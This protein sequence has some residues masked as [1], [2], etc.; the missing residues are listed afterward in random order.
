MSATEQTA[1]NG[2][3]GT[4]APSVETLR[5]QGEALA[6]KVKDLLHEGNVRRI[7]VRNDEGHAVLEIP[8]TA[9]VVAAIVAPVLVAVAALAA[10]ASSWEID[11]DRTAVLVKT[12]RPSDSTPPA[13]MT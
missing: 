13:A 1:N 12:T 6:A 4:R 2:T 11:V 9:G 10:L 5:V 7:T 3:A 8:V